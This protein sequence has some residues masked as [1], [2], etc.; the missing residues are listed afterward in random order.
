MGAAPLLLNP[1][2]VTLSARVRAALAGPDLCHREPE[3]ATLQAG[4]RHGLLEVYEL[5]PGQWSAVLLTGSGTAAVEA[6]VSSLVPQDG[7]LLVLDNGV[8]GDRMARMAAAHGIEHRVL[9][10]PWGEAIDLAALERTL[11]T[12][13][14]FSHLALVHH[15][16]TTGRLNDL[17]PVL[18]RAAAA[19]ARVLLDAVSS[20][21]AE[22]LDFAEGALVACAATANKCLHGVPGVSFVLARRPAL[23]AACSPARSLY[24]DLSAYW[25]QQEAAGTP[26]TQSVQ[27]FYAL[28]EALAEH[29]EAGGWRARRQCYRVRMQRVNEALR[30]AG[31]QPLLEPGAS[32][33]VLNAFRLPAALGYE[34]LHDRLKQAGFVIYAGQGALARSAFRISTMGELSEADIERLQRALRTALGHSPH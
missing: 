24:L 33:C 10:Q 34:T 32:S 7:R 19:G 25:G 8:Y 29:R 3:F 22:E 1:G 11:A 21:G 9:R 2:P 12:E 6:M 27:A 26:F 30:E 5:D 28:R 16:T 17:A 13:G 14:P 18:A 31:V 23:A 20:F 15:E 4:I